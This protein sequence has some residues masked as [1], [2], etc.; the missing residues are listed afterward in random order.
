MINVYE[1]KNDNDNFI[2]LK[3]RAFDEQ[4]NF[5][6]IYYVAIAGTIGFTS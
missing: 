4:L 1:K 6:F 5:S 2:S 3:L